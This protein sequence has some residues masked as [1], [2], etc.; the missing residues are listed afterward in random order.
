M[1]LFVWQKSYNLGVEIIDEQ[2]KNLVQI[3][4][5]LDDLLKGSF[6]S[7]KLESLF[8]E[9]V[10]Y[11]K[12]HFSTEERLMKTRDYGAARIDAH[13]RQHY[14]F[15]QQIQSLHNDAATLDK[16]E[17]EWVLKYLTNWLTNHILKVDRHLAE[18]LINQEEKISAPCKPSLKTSLYKAESLY[19]K[20]GASLDQLNEESLQNPP[21]NPNPEQQSL[22]KQI[23]SELEEV[24]SLLEQALTHAGSAS[25]KMKFEED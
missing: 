23:Q 22:A 1:A 7:K 5:D 10:D 8:S 3:I 20:L 16:Q 15:V 6:C 2:H 12:Y 21:A 24:V 9:L 18:H 17:A 11:T 19:E 25:K 4:N 13:L 14:Q